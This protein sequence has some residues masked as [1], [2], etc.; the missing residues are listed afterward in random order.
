MRLTHDGSKFSKAVESA[1][2]SGGTRD[3]HLIGNDDPEGGLDAIMESV[4]CKED[5]GW[6]DYSRKI[7]VYATDDRFHVAGDGL[8]GAALT[9]NDGRC[10]LE[11]RDIQDY[12]SV[13]QINHVLQQQKVNLILA[14][15]ET[16]FEQY[17]LLQE[18]IEGSSI[19]KLSDDSSNIIDLIKKQYNTITSFVKLKNN[20]RKFTS[21]NATQLIYFRY[22]SGRLQSAFILLPQRM[23]GGNKTKAL[24]Y[25]IK[26]PLF[27]SSPKNAS[28]GEIKRVLAGIL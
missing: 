8:L 28:L 10:H 1:E 27:Y 9:P 4:A 25:L 2:I 21:K 6:R 7:I 15:T 16:Y 17:H 14:V 11:S 22:T 19:G 24:P 12:P 18:T 23:L 13:G 20:P 5:I 26:P 3:G